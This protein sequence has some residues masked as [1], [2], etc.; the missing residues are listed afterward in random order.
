[1]HPALLLGLCIALGIGS[2]LL[3]KRIEKRRRVKRR[4]ERLLL[5]CPYIRL[6]D[7]GKE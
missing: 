7:L 3:S 1:M 5:Q 6:S 4:M 2:F